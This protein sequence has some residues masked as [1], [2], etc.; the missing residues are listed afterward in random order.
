MNV[1]E[2]LW[3]IYEKKWK[4]MKANGNQWKKQWKSMKSN[5]HQWSSMKINENQNQSNLMKIINLPKIKENL[6][7]YENQRESEKNY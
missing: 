5:E 1:N 2:N 3:T 6:R 7:N 4:R